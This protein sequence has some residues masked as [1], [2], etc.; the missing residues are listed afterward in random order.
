MFLFLMPMKNYIN[1]NRYLIVSPIIVLFLT[2][3]FVQFSITLFE[4][5]ISWIPAFVAYYSVITLV[6]VF[7]CKCFSLSIKEIIK[8]NFKPIPQFKFLFWGIFIPALIPLNALLSKYEY[9]PFEFF[10]YIIIFALINPWFEEAFWR[11]FLVQMDKS[12]AFKVIY[13]SVLF[14]FSHYLFWGFWF[15]SPIV[16]LTSVIATTIMGLFWMWFLDRNKHGIIYTI[17][18][19]FFV[20]VFNI[21]V[22]VYCGIISLDKF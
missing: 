7:G 9:I 20:D 15:R 2:W 16:I 10:V 12:K 3:L 19:H 8:V 18:S 1:L 13:S 5:V 14:G 17:I 4:P 22:A 6:M 11:G 21:S